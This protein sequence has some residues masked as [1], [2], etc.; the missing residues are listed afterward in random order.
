VIIVAPRRRD[1]APIGEIARLTDR[2][3]ALRLEIDRLDS[4]L[5]DLLMKRADLAARERLAGGEAVPALRPAR[6][7]ELARS[8][9]RRHAG[10]MTFPP[11]AQILREI[12]MS[13]APLEIF[14]L[15]PEDPASFVEMARSHFGALAKLTRVG[16]SA[17]VLERVRAGGGAIGFLPVPSAAGE[18]WWLRLISG[19]EGAPRIVARLPAIEPPGLDAGAERGFV[20]GC[21]PAE[22]SGDDRT[23]L[24]IEAGAET[25]PGAI[26]KALM[27]AGF[28]AQLLDRANERGLALYLF[29]ADGFLTEGD[30]ARARAAPIE[31]IHVLGVYPVPLEWPPASAAPAE[32]I[33]L[34]L[35]PTTS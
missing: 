18:K 21:L 30:A 26:E 8:F 19:I 4:A 25:T 29:E 34:P 14:L 12:L 32:I 27:A 5:H 6:E 17:S 23:V 33:P 24:A 31:Q 11:V 9:A 16:S 28:K 10:A 20:V 13:R 3:D 1:A 7:A 35:R 2:L 22:P 15:A